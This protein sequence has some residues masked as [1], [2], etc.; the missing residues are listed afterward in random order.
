MKSEK[1]RL[2]ELSKKVREELGVV[3]SCALMLAYAQA[4]DARSRYLKTLN[5]KLEGIETL[6]EEL[7]DAG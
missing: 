5:Q 4:K 2:E 6:L 1:T 7:R 3:R